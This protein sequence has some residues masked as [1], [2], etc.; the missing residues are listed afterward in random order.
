MKH[1]IKRAIHLDF[2][3]MPHIY[4]FNE[5][6]DPV[7]F[8][9]CL[10]KA[11]VK[12][13]N[14][15]AECNLGFAYYDTKLG[16]KYPG[17]K[18]DMLGDIIRECHKRDI[19]VT[20]Y[21][22]L[23][24][25]HE[26][27]RTH[28]EWCKVNANGQILSGDRTDSGFRHP[29]LGTS[30]ADHMYAMIQ[31]LITLHPEIDG[32]FLDCINFLPCYGNECLEAI[33]AA[34]GDPLDDEQVK[35]HT[36][37]I[38]MNFLAKVKKLIG[39]RNMICNSNSYWLMKDFNSHVEVESL[40]GE[41]RWWGYQYFSQQAAYAR[42]ITD[43]YLYMSGRFHKSWGDFGGLK[44]KESMQNDMWEA[45]ANG[46]EIS[47]GDHMH[48]AENLDPA[49]YKVIGEIYEEKMALEPWTDGAKYQ[50]DIGVLVSSDN[51]SLMIHTD[52]ETGCYAGLACMLNQLHYSYD[53]L[54]DTMDF[55]RYQLLIVPDN[56][57]FDEK[58]KAKVSEFLASGKPV[59][60]TGEGGL[61]L[62]EDKF[63][64]PQ[65]KIN[66]VGKDTSTAPF[67]TRPG[68]KFRYAIYQPGIHMTAPDAD[69][70]YAQYVQG[71]FNKTW[72]GFHGNAYFPPEKPNGEQVAVRTGNVVHIGFK[73]FTD[74]D[75]AGYIE[76][77]KLVAECLAD[78]LPNPRFTCTGLP[79]TAHVTLTAKET[80]TLLHVRVTYPEYRGEI[81]VV[82]EHN[83]QPAGAQVTLDGIYPEAYSIPDKTPIALTQANG[84]TTLT[85]PQ[86][87][88]YLCVALPNP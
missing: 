62:L 24:I 73:V 68:D 37:D 63:A 61:E 84:K 10:E 8:A 1:E 29:C 72:D 28:R 66:V 46:A 54:N 49:V 22:N 88:G 9:E 17:L 27:C 86:I 83:V 25:N 65:W 60:S 42:N 5:T 44:S 18:G 55:S 57:R 7:A 19:G 40:T 75:S 23:G 13:I 36:H 38:T 85:L 34:G 15:F 87:T 14:A 26:A 67:Y 69:K 12:Y 31:E 32:I 6:W 82:E 58:M 76:H 70:I 30:Y 53:I 33:A 3:T 78:L 79:S 48:P 50:A 45:V 56:L 59:L 16:T 51:M 81:N 11:H 74:Y 39:D 20:G 35:Q 47:F 4:N 77:K 43:H 80:Y 64:L 52:E 21:F 2:H 41:S 71:Y